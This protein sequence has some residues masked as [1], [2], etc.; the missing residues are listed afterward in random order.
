MTVLV[1]TAPLLAAYLGFGTLRRFPK[2]DQPFVVSALILFGCLIFGLISM[3]LADRFQDVGVAASG[4]VN[5]F[6]PPEEYSLDESRL[7]SG[8]AQIW[9]T[10]IF[11]WLRGTTINHIFGFGPESWDRVYPLYAH[12]TLVSSLYE[13]G[14][15]GVIGD[16]WLWFSML[17]AAL[18]VRHPQ[19]GTLVGAH[20]SF[21]VLNMSTMPMWM[22]EGNL[23]Y[24]V[25]CGYTLYL[26]SLQGRRSAP[27]KPSTARSHPVPGL[28][29]RAK[30]VSPR[31][32]R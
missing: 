1:A 32:L 8:R 31:G 29:Q 27:V 25:I 24:G 26:L 3:A 18:R 10:Y 20:V 6:K 12:N 19:R 23:L 5:F 22:I 21:I 15:W 9:S 2:R 14:F 28:E 7:L 11:G 13:Y 4:Q 30:P 16:L 17:A